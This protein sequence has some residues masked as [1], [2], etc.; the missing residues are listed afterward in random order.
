VTD[1]I[2]LPHAAALHMRD[3]LRGIVDAADDDCGEEGCRDCAPVRVMRAALAALA[4]ALAEPEHIH[5]CGPDCQRPIC[6]N[7]R[8][9]AAAAVEAEREACA[10]YAA[11]LA[12]AGWSAESIADALRGRK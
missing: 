11:A 8:R 2:T 5:T 4:A 12:E 7:R 1:T 10:E 9:E 6:V 3:A